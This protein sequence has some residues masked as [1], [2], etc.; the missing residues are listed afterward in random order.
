VARYTCKRVNDLMNKRHKTGL[1]TKG[2]GMTVDDEGSPSMEDKTAGSS[3]GPSPKSPIDYYLRDAHSRIADIGSGK[4]WYDVTYKV[5]RGIS[6]TS[7]SR[8]LP[9]A[10]RSSRKSPVARAAMRACS[11][12]CGPGRVR[13]TGSA[14]ISWFVV[15]LCC[16]WVISVD[17]LR[18]WAL[19]ERPITV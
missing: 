16:E 4:R 2:G 1:A 10:I 12:S 6:R 7:I 11:S 18:G 5:A 17:W 13:F 15:M 3:N 14:T 9:D 19:A 8:R